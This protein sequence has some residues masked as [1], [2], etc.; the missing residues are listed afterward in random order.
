MKNPN[1]YGSVYKLSG[2]RRKPYAARITIGFKDNEATGKSY[3][4]YKFLGYYVTRKEAITALA[5]YN[6][7]PDAVVT[8][9]NT[10][11]PT[12]KITLHKVFEEWSEEHLTKLKNSGTYYSSFKV[13]EP[14]YDHPFESLKIN[15]YEDIFNKS[16]K[17][18]PVLLI[19]KSCLRQ[20][21]GYAFRKGYITQ[22]DVNIPTYISLEHVKSGK[23]EGFRMVFTKKEIAT[24]WEHQ[25][26]IGAKVI[27]FMIYTGLRISEV[28]ALQPEDVHLE[29]RY[30]DVRASKTEAGVRKVPIAKKILPFMKEWVE[31]G[32]EFVVP[33]RGAAKTTRKTASSNGFDATLKNLGIQRH[34]QHDT[35]HTCSSLLTEAEVDLRFIELI[36]GHQMKDITNKVYANKLDI[37]VLIEAIDKI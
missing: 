35:R 4:I 28:A 12:N 22:A 15:D 3:P 25:E 23:K 19:A 16:K 36:I 14:L 10:L 9:N 26:D 32:S 33:L 2:N 11:T 37:S 5:L 17:N 13:L 8:V 1:G 30:F 27:L 21:Y 34:T 18:R 29:E 24:L 20:M 6:A 31:S 7:N